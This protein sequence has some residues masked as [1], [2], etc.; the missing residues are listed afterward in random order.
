MKKLLLE[1]DGLKVES[2]E[3]GEDASGAGTVRAYEGGCS[4]GRTCGNPSRDDEGYEEFARTLYGC[5]V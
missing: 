1:L 3:P 2:F 4:V 5:C